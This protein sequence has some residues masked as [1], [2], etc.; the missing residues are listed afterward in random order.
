[1]DNID[2]LVMEE[3]RSLSRDFQKRV[4]SYQVA[5]SWERMKSNRIK[6]SI[7]LDYFCFYRWFVHSGNLSVKKTLARKA[8][9]YTEHAEFEFKLRTSKFGWN[10]EGSGCLVGVDQIAN[11]QQKAEIRV[12]FILVAPGDSCQEVGQLKFSMFYIC[13]EA[14]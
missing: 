3:M 1:M 7:F 2:Y 10:R 12:F 5:N 9:V 14:G 8:S 11:F 4:Q 6:Y 13:S